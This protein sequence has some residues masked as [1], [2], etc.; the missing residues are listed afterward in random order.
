MDFRFLLLLL[1][2]FLSGFAALLYQ[3][4]WTREFAFLFGTSELAVVAVLAAYMGG[5]AL[6]AAAAARF[7]GRLTRPVLAYGLLELGIALCALAVPLGIR[8]VQGLYLGIAGG[9]D[10]PPETM[11]LSTALFHLIGSFLVLV[12]CTALM[13]ATLPL[14]ARYA[15]SEDEQLGPRIGILY[16]V[17]TFGAIGGTLVAAFVLLPAIGLRQTVYVGIAGNALVFVLAA[18]LARNIG[19][20]APE[21]E[22]LDRSTHGRFHWILPAMTLSGAV[23]FLYEVLWTRLLG[24][25]LGGSTAAFA[26][27]LSSFLLGI[28]LGS[29]I[30]S[31]FAKTREAALTGFAVAQL[32]IGVL[33]W[34][35]FR[36][37]ESLPALAHAVGANPSAPAPGAAAAGLVLLP[38]TLCIGATFPFGVRLLALDAEEAASV[39]GRVYAW[40][41][42]GSIIGAVA[43]GFFLLPALGLENTALVGVVCSLLLAA[44]A[45]YFSAP[46]RSVLAGLAAGALVLAVAIGLPTPDRL[47]MHSAISGTRMAGDLLYLGVGR[48]AT[49]T[50]V[51]NEQGYRLLTNGLPESGIDRAHLPNPRFSE[52]AW[53]SLLP[54]A[55]RPETDRMLIIGLGAGR[56]LQA[57][58]GTLSH[59]DVIELEEEV[60]VANRLI[61]RAVDPLDNPRVHLR[62]GDARGAM[63]LSDAR[64]DAIVSQPSH[65]WTSGASHLYTQEFFELVDTKLEPGGIFVQWI[66]ASFVDETLFGNLMAAMTQ[67]FPH[68]HV[69]RPVPAALVFMASAE[70]IDLVRSAPRALAAAPDDFGRQGIHRVED[71]FASWT[72]DTDG[73]R[74][75]SRDLPPNTDDHNRLATRRLPPSTRAGGGV[76]LAELNAAFSKQDA[77]ATGALGRVDPVAVLRRLAWLGDRPRIGALAPQLSPE[78]RFAALGWIDFDDGRLRRAAS[79]FARALEADPSHPSARAGLLSIGRPSDVPPGDLSGEEKA[80][81]AANAALAAEDWSALAALDPALAKIG[82]AHFLFSRTTRLRSEW[83]IRSGDVGAAKEAVD[84]TDALL[85]RERSG[86]HYLLHAR[87]AAAAGDTPRAWATLDAVATARR[88]PRPTVLAAMELARSLGTPPEG[89]QTL[90]RLGRVL[91]RRG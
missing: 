55:A 53:L 24:Q 8:L 57:A 14:L 83:R 33:A 62:L 77:L 15:V 7:V 48:S 21:S 5:L 34:V 84:L 17:N 51:E 86:P 54:T 13:G 28:A 11:A 22:F 87:A 64:Y 29:A 46:R 9:L 50:V 73:V 27:M 60:V 41:T 36:A 75:L 74:S 69:Y 90:K 32:G 45:A 68:V 16:A 1:C 2:F 31:R 44:A 52:T 47:L 35:A 79:L 6:G 71:F 23:S 20:M 66:G 80:V 19:G 49:V 91:G 85:T 70:P 39:S 65:P 63:N 67:V 3:T 40:N 56:T 78:D 26:S 88:L 4:A 81:A 37:S 72:L 30:A 10:A 59:I 42:V 18:I 82:A 76:R 43:A 58:A 12:P 89:S 38:V 61:P 25:V